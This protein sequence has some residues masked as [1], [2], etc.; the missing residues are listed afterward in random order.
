[1]S[2][3]EKSNA[4]SS[5]SPAAGNPAAVGPES[6]SVEFEVNRLRWALWSVCGGAGGIFLIAKFGVLARWAGVVLLGLAAYHGFWLVMS[7]LNPPGAIVVTPTTVR[8]PRG[9]C[10]GTPQDLA[11]QQVRAAYFLRHSVPWNRSAPLLIIETQGD[12][13]A[14]AY[15][16]TYPRDWFTTEADQRRV[17]SAIVAHL[18]AHADGGASST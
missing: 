11:M 18:P 4:A 9:L 16:H 2:T 15:A 7:L 10:R 5:S 14:S 12:G 3:N 8:L 1:M 17:I 6:V 13:A